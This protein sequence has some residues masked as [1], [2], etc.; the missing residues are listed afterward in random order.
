MND[1]SH[2]I[3]TSLTYEVRFAARAQS[4]LDVATLY[5]AKTVSPDV[6]IAWREGI[7]QAISSLTT[8]PRRCPHAPQKFRHE[9]RQLL[10]RRPGSKIIYR[11]LFTITGEATALGGVP[12]VYILHIRHSSTRPITRKQAR[13]IE[14]EL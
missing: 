3:D 8:L 2:S 4:D 12:T 5:F 11:I 1:P 13:I 6:A 9:V 7:Y 10:Y 14:E